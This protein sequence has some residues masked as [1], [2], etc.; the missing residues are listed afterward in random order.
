MYFEF[1]TSLIKNKDICMF[2]F[3]IN[4][5]FEIYLGSGNDL[6]IILLVNII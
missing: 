2:L 6:N 5:F 1:I 4:C 3:F